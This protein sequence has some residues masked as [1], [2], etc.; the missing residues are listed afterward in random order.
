MTMISSKH[1]FPICFF[2]LSHFDNQ[3]DICSDQVLKS[4]GALLSDILDG[5]LVLG[6]VVVLL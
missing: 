5:L 3:I 6:V 2:I 1:E 4:F